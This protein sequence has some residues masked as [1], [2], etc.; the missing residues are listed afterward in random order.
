MIQLKCYDS[1]S[2]IT[3][4]YVDLYKDSPIKLTLS[5]EDITNAE[6]TSVFSRSF[7]IPNTPTNAKYFKHAFLIEGIDFDI[8]IKKPAE[9]IVDGSEFRTG[10]IRLQKI[11]NNKDLDKIDYEILFL[12]ETKDF[13]TV[14]GD[15][16]M[17]DLDIADL[18]HSFTFATIQ[19]SWGAYPSTT[20]WDTVTDDFVTQTPTI[21]SGL[22]DGNVIYPLINH[23]NTYGE[24]G[25]V[26][27]YDPVS[28]AV[29][30][31]QVGIGSNADHYFNHPGGELSA[32]Q[33]KPMVRVKRLWDAIFEFAG[34]T[35]TSD[36]INP[37]DPEDSVFT[38]LYASSFGNEASIRFD[39]TRSS[40][41]TF[42]AEGL[43]ED[44]NVDEYMECEQEL[45][46]LGNNY[47][48]N[49]SRYTVPDDGTYTFFM[50]AYVG[51]EFETPSSGTEL[52][53]SVLELRVTS[54][55]VETVVATSP[56][57][58][59]QV[60]S[61]THS[62]PLTAGDTVKVFVAYVGSNEPSASNTSSH[63]FACTVSPGD[64]NPVFNFD[65]EYKQIDFIKDV[66]TTF[67][68][69]MSPDYSKPN[70]F[71]I[72]PFVNYIASGDTHDWSDKLDQT[73]DLIIEPL[74]FTQSDRIDY[75]HAAD[76][77]YI[78]AYHIAAYKEA[79]GYLEFDSGNDLLKGARTIETLWAPTPMTHIEGTPTTSSFILPQL[80]VHE[81]GDIN[82][83]HLPI[84]P[85]TRFLF[86]NGLQPIT[87]NSYRWHLE[88]VADPMD[89]YP[90]V[91]YSSEW[92]M[93]GT[94]T[95]LNWNVDIGYWGNSVSGYP[96][97]LGQSMYDLY[98]AGYIGSLYSRNARR[99][100]GTFI[101]NSVD[102]QDFSFDDVIYVNGV[103]Y[104]PE[105]I[106]DAQIGELSP[107][108]VQLI[109]LLNY[110][111]LILPPLP[112]ITTYFIEACDGSFG[113]F[114]TSGIPNLAVGTVMQIV[115][116]GVDPVCVVVGQSTTPQQ[117]ITD[118]LIDGA[119]Y[120]NCNSC[121][122][123]T[124][125]T[126]ESVY[127]ITECGTT[128]GGQAASTGY[129]FNVGD[130]VQYT[131]GGTGATYCGTIQSEVQG[132]NPVI[133]INSPIAY[134]CDD[135]VHCGQ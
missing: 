55:G 99:V 48:A 125:P 17:C 104:R 65:C 105:K 4:T 3:P 14:I 25:R 95:I 108:K 51:A 114:A 86:Y 107:T 126:T 36:F 103:Y 23:G 124:P 16:S 62:E 70:N 27:R 91:S 78:N 131:I 18:T 39:A 50:S 101:L 119:T 116:E 123:V 89:H 29:L 30:Q 106:L 44:G 57:G 58:V 5:V 45:S 32:A 98:W 73:K 113:S 90:L 88:G 132:V 102:L 56:Q 87:T 60:V 24:D 67:R 38:S 43:G 42:S 85:K 97:R 127:N 117:G 128:Q 53:D 6:A 20:K 84:K 96:S 54:G 37:V 19:E 15:R 12:G 46:D 83:Q 80:H 41:N 77:D 82:T 109:K 133:V 47:N 64:M 121:N 61:L 9:I 21:T 111:E 122:G 59:D 134:A 28:G 71:I 110:T 93:T 76:G 2:K 66:L 69:V 74:F 52:V 129:N 92:P 40:Q 7:R 34:Y 11:Y 63:Q 118:T 10:H 8:T 79:F 13:S 33:F 68:L 1:P 81:A 35:Y 72:E 120:L 135:E 49:L 112:S 22:N 94:G 26:I 75:K 115:T 31:G 130:V 100:T